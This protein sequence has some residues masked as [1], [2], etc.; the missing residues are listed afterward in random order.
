MRTFLISAL[1]GVVALVGKTWADEEKIS[2]DKLPPAVS[3]A[4]KK[5]FPKAEI[6]G[7]SKEVEDGKTMY[8]ISLK[9]D[10]RKIDATFTVEGTLATIEKQITAKEL[11]K[12]VAA[13]LSSKYP[14]ATYKT[15]EEVIQ[16]K[17]GNE[18]L[19][20]YETLLETADHKQV[21]VEIGADGMIKKTEDKT[22]KKD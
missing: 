19:A 18:T 20:Y 9:D 12:A 16:V 15:L 6:T 14:G 10:G 8:E 22:G 5:R 7:A 1:V 13:T 21:E 2:S 4:A 3:A 17:D 11:P